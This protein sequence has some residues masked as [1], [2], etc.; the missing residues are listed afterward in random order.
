[1]D[2]QTVWEVECRTKWGYDHGDIRV[3]LF[4]VRNDELEET[5]DAIVLSV[6]TSIIIASSDI[7]AILTKAIIYCLLRSPECKQK[8]IQGLETRTMLEHTKHIP[9]LQACLCEGLRCHQGMEMSLPRVKSLV[10]LFRRVYGWLLP[11]GIHADNHLDELW[12]QSIG[13]TSKFLRSS[14]KAS[15]TSAQNVG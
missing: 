13:N 7:T 11:Y 14:E 4:D 10:A 8:L 6:A 3:K 15:S 2:L 9:Y 5:S 12:G 1:M